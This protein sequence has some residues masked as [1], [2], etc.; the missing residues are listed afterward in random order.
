LPAKQKAPNFIVRI[1]GR[2]ERFVLKVL[3]PEIQ[4]RQRRGDSWNSQPSITHKLW[5]N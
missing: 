3:K 2:A 4:G 1:H 5:G